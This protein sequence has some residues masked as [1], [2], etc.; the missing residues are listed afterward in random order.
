MGVIEVTIS[1][2]IDKSGA[3]Q[4][5][6]ILMEL[7]LENMQKNKYLAGNIHKIDLVR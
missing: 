5:F 3:D 2:K 7:I 6:D 4:K 1:L